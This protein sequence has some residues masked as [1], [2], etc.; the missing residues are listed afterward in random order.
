M[1]LENEALLIPVER[2]HLLTRKLVWFLLDNMIKVIS[3]SH[4]NI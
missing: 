4:F 1:I 3:L 2:L